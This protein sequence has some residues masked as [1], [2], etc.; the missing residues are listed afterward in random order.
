MYRGFPELVID[1]RYVLGS[2]PMDFTSTA[3]EDCESGKVERM[4][5]LVGDL[6]GYGLGGIG[7]QDRTA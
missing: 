1:F 5:D 4:G 7:E 3:V 6:L 2:G